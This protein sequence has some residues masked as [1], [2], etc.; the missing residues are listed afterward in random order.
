MRKALVVGI[1]YYE[2]ISPL[3]GCVNDSFKVKMVLD[4]H[5]DGSV[6]FDVKHL[7][8]TGPGTGI[9]RRELK[10]SAAELFRDK[11][12]I[13]LFYFAGHGFIESTG[14]FLIT[15]DCEDGDEGF[16]LDELMQLANNSPS[17]NKVIILDSCHSGIAGTPKALGNSA[18]INEGITILTASSEH[19]YAMEENGSGVF[20]TLLVDAL[21]GGAAN[22]VGEVTPGSIYAHID[23]SLGR[24]EQRPIFKTNVETFTPLRRVQP[25]IELSD[26][27]RI[28]ELFK[29]PAEILKLDPSFEPEGSHEKN[30]DN[31]EKF[32]MLQKYN[33][34]NLVIPDG[35]PHMW[36]A[37]MN[38]QGCRLTVLGAHY[39]T[40]VHK[41][42]I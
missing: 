18:F 29:H 16:K 15:S 24:W 20:T 36:H 8:G 9:S 25:P 31:M 35:A 34:I 40:L 38:S 39:W 41:G 13:A 2:K 28:T 11:N 12:E 33:R 7:T 6:N 17:T 10:D 14:G 21:D 37:A 5:S 3:H 42:R 19:Q 26:L 27:K 1:D 30:K 4:R 22:L 32:E 23:Q